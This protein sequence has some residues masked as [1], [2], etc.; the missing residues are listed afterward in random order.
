[1]SSKSSSN[2]SSVKRKVQ[3]VQQIPPPASP[4]PAKQIKKEPIVE[5]LKVYTIYSFLYPINI[6]SFFLVTTST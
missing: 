5:K 4:T 1:M 2:T 6:L 3:I